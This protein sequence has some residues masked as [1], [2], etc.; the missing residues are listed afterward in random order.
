MKSILGVE[1]DEQTQDRIEE[2]ATRLDELSAELRRQAGRNKTK[3]EKATINRM[4]REFKEV[5]RDTFRGLYSSYSAESGG[6]G[7][8]TQEERNRLDNQI[9]V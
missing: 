7:S 1:V 9:D 5:A 2:M 6:P 3:K 8:I 4:K